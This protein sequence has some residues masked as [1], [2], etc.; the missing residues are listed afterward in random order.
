MLNTAV[1]T[2]LAFIYVPLNL[3]TSIFGMNI[4]QLNRSGQNIS[5]FLV[6]ALIALV[7]T[8]GA[9]YLMEQVNSYL[10]WR[11]ARLRKDDHKRT[12][13][14]IMT[15]INMLVW[16]S[17]SRYK[18]WVIK[19]GIWWRLLTNSRSRLCSDKDTVVN[20]KFHPTAAE[21]VS[22]YICTSGVCWEPKYYQDSV[23]KLGPPGNGGRE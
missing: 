4:Y 15:R 16:V 14:P 13:F 1:V 22:R 9:W 2:V 7:V 12:K 11:T 10:K 17:L 20:P 6:T 8:G 18:Y 23:W 3:A 21:F 5:V 19:R